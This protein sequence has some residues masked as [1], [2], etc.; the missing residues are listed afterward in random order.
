MVPV[1]LAFMG[2]TEKR[3]EIIIYGRVDKSNNSGYRGRNYRM[4]ADQQYR[5]YDSGGRIYQ[6]ECKYAVQRILSGGDSAGGHSG[7]GG[8][9]LE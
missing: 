6:A 2:K 5:A 7:S 3:E 8:T 9:V 4:A 1:L